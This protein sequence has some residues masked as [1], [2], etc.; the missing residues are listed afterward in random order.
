MAGSV[1]V[2]GLKPLARRLKAIDKSY[3][4]ELRKAMLLVSDLMATASVTAA[5]RR[6]KKAIKG[7]ATQK[8][9]FVRVS[10]GRRGDSL[11]VVMGQ[12]QR[13]GWYGFRR[14]RPSTGRQFRPWAGNQWDPGDSTAMPYE[15]GPA[16]NET[17][18][19]AVDI[20]GDALQ[21]LIDRAFR[22]GP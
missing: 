15:I 13:S 6:A 20:L 7:R 9:A 10:S 1:R 22:E 3:G 21:D 16:I 2:K 4:K 11:A 5:D 17:V 12:K 14:Y 18:P 8:S 19:E